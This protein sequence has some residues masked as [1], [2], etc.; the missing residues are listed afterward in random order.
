[1]SKSK[2]S[3]K[4]FFEKR[5]QGFSEQLLI[6]K[7][8]IK[9]LST[10]RVIIFLST[11]LGIY[12]A[13][14]LGWVLVITVAVLGFGIFIFL[15]IKQSKLLKNT[16]R[17]EALVA[18]NETELALLARKG[19]DKNDGKKHLSE[20]HPFAADLDVFGK[21]SLF[22]L[23]A[24]SATCQGE[25]KLAET[26]NSLLKN[27][28]LLLKRQQA[29]NE[30]AGK[31]EW[32]QEFEAIGK[33]SSE[34]TPSTNSL[35]S[36][37]GEK[38]SFFNKPV[39][40]FLLFLN[41]IIGFGVVFLILFF[42]F[43]FSLFL[44]FLLLPFS[45]F[46]PKL[47]LINSQHGLL[48]RKTELLNKYASLFSLFEKEEF[49]SEI[50][51]NNK[52][53]LAGNQNSA[54]EAVQNLSKIS[55]KFDYRLNFLVGI[56][57]NIFFLW[58][59]IQSI[60]LEKWKSQHGVFLKKWFESLAEIDEL[61]SFA[62]F[63]FAHPEAIFPKISETDFE[64]I[65]TNMKHPFLESEKCVGNGIS[66]EGLGQFRIITGAN[67]AGKSTY[68]RTV[69]I[70]LVLAMTGSP[71]LADS[72]VFTPVD[73]FT[74][75]KTSDSLQDGESYFF[76]ELKRLKE[77]ITHLEK[78]ETLFV[79]LDEILRG[80]NSADKQKGSKALIRQLL[81]LK[82]SGLIA[83]HDL[84]L[85]ELAALFP[86]NVQNQRFEVEIENNEL[87]FDYLLKEGVSQNLNATFL[88][89]KMGIT[90]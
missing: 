52:H 19:E 46:V 80:T 6:T 66:I 68:L 59:I 21:K 87:K 69:G 2:E 40:H 22:Q 34:T 84:A 33:L 89:K 70:N 79:I 17:L 23:I 38:D 10:I 39:Y 64:L 62:G 56:F 43:N 20:H 42:G 72:F 29:I 75:I 32:R 50:I 48:S 77:I 61:S 88:M 12:F 37:A 76:A 8:A 4:D 24:R 49:T 81:N 36:W 5:L 83:T 65:A 45:I 53:L 63:A 25:E 15:V 55:A 30:L 18:V 78:G 74:G 35:V 14:S 26:L 31:P 9:R 90:L 16:A 47:K 44:L 54:S 27:R 51:Q 3:V 86:K 41:P 1:M 58:D 71:V 60:R 28:E 73:L 13:T 57:L 7:S 67:M 85:G 11:V 82:A